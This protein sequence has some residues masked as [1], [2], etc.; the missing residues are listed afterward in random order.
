M[1]SLSIL[2]FATSPADRRGIHVGDLFIPLGPQGTSSSTAGRPSG[3]PN[4]SPSPSGSKSPVAA[5]PTPTPVKPVPPPPLPVGLSGTWVL[6]QANSVS[7]V[8]PSYVEVALSTPRVRGFS[9]RVPWS[10]IDGSTAILTAGAQT[11]AKHHMPLVIRF[12]AGMGTPARVFAAGSPYYISNGVKVP[13][14]FMPDGS[15]NTIFES[16]YKSEVAALA[17]WCHA[18]GVHELHMSWY[19]RLYAQLDNSSIVNAQPGYTYA[20][21]LTAYERLVAIAWAYASSSLTIEFPVDGTDTTHH[22]T[23]DLTRYIDSIAASHPTWFYQQ[24]NGLGVYN[25]PPLGTVPHGQQMYGTADYDWS[26]IY[27]IA[28]QNKDVYLEIYA[29]SFGATLLHHVSLM[30]QVASFL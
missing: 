24:T 8:D 21:W 27:S 20:H 30:T 17:A 23:G 1:L 29:S 5:K 7:Q 4:A 3:A 22:A 15:P 2:D 16:Y 18:N 19:G 26:S 6:Q 12:M 11:A 13:T 28:K 9:L 25:A 10:A 14:P